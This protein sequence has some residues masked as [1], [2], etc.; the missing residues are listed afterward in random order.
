LKEL[1][2]SPEDEKTVSASYIAMTILSIQAKT[3]VEV[4]KHVF[5]NNEAP[6]V[7]KK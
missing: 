5:F 3:R 4:P 7:K 2:K 1:L 6:E